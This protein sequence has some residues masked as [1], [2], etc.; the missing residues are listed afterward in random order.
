MTTQELHDAILANAE[1]KA[2]ADAGNDSGCAALISPLL[3][4]VRRET[5]MTYIEVMNALGHALGARLITSVNAAAASGHPVL[6]P[7]LDEA[8]HS[9]RGNGVDLAHTDT[10]QM[11]DTLVARATL[12]GLTAADA[13]ALKGLAE[14]PQVIDAGEVGKAWAQYRPGGIVGD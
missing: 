2:L 1:A 5:R 13:A 7:V 11:L 9:L 6:G 10:R 3:P 8:R 14:H 12:N 4:K